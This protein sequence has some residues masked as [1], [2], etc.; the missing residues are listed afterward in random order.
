MGSAFV[1]WFYIFKTL[2]FGN[3]K[4]DTCCFWVQEPQ[5]LA[6]CPVYSIHIHLFSSC[7]SLLLAGSWPDF[8]CGGLSWSF[9]VV[10]CRSLS[11]HPPPTLLYCLLFPGTSSCP[12]LSCLAI[13]VDMHSWGNSE[14]LPWEPEWACVAQIGTQWI[15][16]SLLW[17]Q[18]KDQLPS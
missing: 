1:Y 13:V 3:F 11:D 8:P 7:Y 12:H 9:T 2:V 10:R 15:L 16:G 14:T 17:K 18:S 4:C 6:W 5:L